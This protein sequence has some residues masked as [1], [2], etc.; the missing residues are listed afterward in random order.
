MIVVSAHDAYQVVISEPDFTAGVPAT[1]ASLESNNITFE[2]ASTYDSYLDAWPAIAN[3]QSSI[4]SLQKNGTSQWTDLAP[5]E[6][7]NRY[8]S[9]QYD[10]F[11]S[12][13]LFTNWTSPQTQNNSAL[14]LAA[15]AGSGIH[16]E[17]GLLDLC[18]PAFLA[19][20]Q[21]SFS[22]PSQYQLAPETGL[23]IT[24]FDIELCLSYAKGDRLQA[25]YSGVK[26]QH[27]LSQNVQDECVLVTT[28]MVWKALTI[29]VAVQTL[30]MLAAL[31][32][33]PQTP[34]LVVGDAIASFL[35][36]PDTVKNR[37]V[38]DMLFDSLIMGTESCI[39]LA[40]LVWLTVNIV[41]V[42]VLPGR[43]IGFVQPDE[44]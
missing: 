25:T 7:A 8:E 33:C 42:M 11:S 1:L 21:T 19:A 39:S 44:S 2:K 10:S 35:S 15:L 30:A 18:P 4:S 27:C 13:I 38:S 41:I 24:A 40:L 20:N 34:L 32:C 5:V 43:K 6:C 9:E 23:F 14:V 31:A 36:R 22:T 29:F 16:A 17:R 37:H 12:V 3:L 26:V 28:P